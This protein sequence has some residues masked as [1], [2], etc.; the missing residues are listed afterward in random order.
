MK[1][2]DGTLMDAGCDAVFGGAK[3]EKFDRESY[4]V[5]IHFQNGKKV[6][7]PYLWLFWQLPGV[8]L[9]VLSGR[10]QIYRS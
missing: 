8:F 10:G 4:T 6:W 5:H 9:P 3:I 2:P 1:I 7:I